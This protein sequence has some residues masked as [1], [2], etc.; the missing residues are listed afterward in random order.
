MSA[1]VQDRADSADD[2]SADDPSTAADQD[3][4]VAVV[5]LEKRRPDVGADPEYPDLCARDAAAVKSLK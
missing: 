2:R 5:D 3:S 4:D 1:L